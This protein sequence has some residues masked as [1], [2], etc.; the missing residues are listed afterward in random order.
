MCRIVGTDGKGIIDIVNWCDIELNAE[1]R[2]TTVNG[3]VTLTQDDNAVTLVQRYDIQQVTEL[4]APLPCTAYLLADEA[5]VLRVLI[6]RVHI[7]VQGDDGVTTE[8]GVQRIIAHQAIGQ[9]SCRQVAAYSVVQML[10]V[11]R[12]RILTSAAF[13]I[14]TVD[15]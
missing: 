1:G 10:V 3:S 14:C 6:D 4:I 2:V 15:R 5:C 12:P 9:M 13:D 7:E 11:I 8:N